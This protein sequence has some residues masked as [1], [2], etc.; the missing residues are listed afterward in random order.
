MPDIKSLPKW[1][2]ELISLQAQEIDSLKLQ[3]Q[4]LEGGI[5]DSPVSRWNLMH[6]YLAPNEMYRFRLTDYS[7]VDVRLATLNVSADN[8]DPV[9]DIDGSDYLTVAP[10]VSNHIQ[11]WSRDRF[12]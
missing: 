9:L 8:A 3:V 7:H 10:I 5:K 4:T 12:Q 1:A 6:E 11:L 2:Q